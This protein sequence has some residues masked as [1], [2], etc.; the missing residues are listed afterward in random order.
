MLPRASWLL[1]EA[2][3]P[4]S[5]ELPEFKISMSNQQN[6][7]VCGAGLSPLETIN[8][9]P[10]RSPQHLLS[11]LLPVLGMMDTSAIPVLGGQVEVAG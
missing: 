9:Y 3:N 10:P 1:K 7:A 2:R 6:P 8:M 4:G 11:V 5:V